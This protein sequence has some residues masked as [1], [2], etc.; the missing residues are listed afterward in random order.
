MAKLPYMQFYPADWLLDTLT[1]SPSARGIWID[2]LSFMWRAEPRTGMMECTVEGWCKRL[3]CT[4]AAFRLAVEELTL[5]HIC[6]V[7]TDPCKDLVRFTCRRLVREE[8]LRGT[9]NLYVSKYRSK[10]ARKENVRSVKGACK[11]ENQN[12]NQNQNHISESSSEIIVKEKKEKTP[13]PPT[14][15]VVCVSDPFEQF[16]K[17]YPRKVGKAAARKVWDKIKDRP[18]VIH[19]TEAVERAV[20]TD[21]WKKDNGQFIPHPAT[22]LNRGQWA[23]EP[24]ESI[25]AND[26]NGFLAGL[27]SFIAR[28]S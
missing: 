23:D 20:Q 9:N 11:V 10:I 18:P 25:G 27:N 14:G 24:V 15:G 19:L 22:W 4:D 16:W 26:P 8:K 12:Q 28:G 21:Q 3:R 2:I 1:I 6:E 13:L 7:R 5:E 17:V